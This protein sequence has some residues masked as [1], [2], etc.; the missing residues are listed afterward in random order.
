MSTATY[1]GVSYDTTLRH[2]NELEMIKRQLEKAKARH[3]AELVR[4]RMR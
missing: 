2:I 3:E 4:A 1:R